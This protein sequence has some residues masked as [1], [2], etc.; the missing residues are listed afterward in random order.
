[1]K[2]EK[3]QVNSSTFLCEIQPS[4]TARKTAAKTAPKVVTV[5]DIMGTG[6]NSYPCLFPDYPKSTV[7]R[8]EAQWPYQRTTAHQN[9]PK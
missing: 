8:R 4:K 1:M 5:A 6:L 7:A 9:K 3:I 2:V